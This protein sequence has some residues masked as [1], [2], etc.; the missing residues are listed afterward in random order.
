MLGGNLAAQLKYN[1]TWVFGSDY[2]FDIPGIETTIIDFNRSPP[3]HRNVVGLIELTTG[4]AQIS[5]PIS[6]RLLFYTNGCKIID[7]THQVMENG[8]RI[9]E[10]EYYN[11]FCEGSIGYYPLS[12]S[13]L[14]LPNLIEDHGYYMIHK[15]KYFDSLVCSDLRYSYIDMSKNNG[16][17]SVTIKN[18]LIDDSKNFS[19]GYLTA[20]KHGNQKDWWIIQSR[21]D[22]NLFH[23]YLLQ[24]EGIES[25][26][27]Q[28]IG[29]PLWHPGQATFTPDGMRYVAYDDGKG[30]LCMDFN[31][32]TGYFSNTR[33]AQI[34]YDSLLGGLAISPNS[35]FAYAILD[36]EIYQVD[37]ME[38]DLSD[39]IV[40]V[41]TAREDIGT[42]FEQNFGSA[43]LGPDCKVYVAPGS[44]SRAMHVIHKPD[45]KGIECDVRQ[46]DVKFF[47][48]RSNA[49]LHS[50]INYNIDEER[51]CDPTITM[52]DATQL[53]D[54]L[55]IKI[56]PNPTSDYIIVQNASIFS[57]ANI[58]IYDLSGRLVH[59]THQA[60]DQKID[61]RSLPKGIYIIE[62]VTDDF[63]RWRTK[64][65]KE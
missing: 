58:N 64:F 35:R 61:V 56:A 38:E 22:S 39:G 48:S 63:K 7:S 3:E 51:Y 1:Y 43:T 29:V 36:K 27:V 62:C 17:G 52:Y 57:E 20:I 15:T 60:L 59:H 4:P 16:L 26:D 5:D 11:N 55:D 18:Q 23:T 19:C 45:L 28:E 21:Q 53:P 50:Y 25:F 34:K 30:I 24:N 2:D 40:K 33:F 37:L 12:N 41:A 32:N 54:H 9:N 6:G 49:Y 31:R 13:I 47:Y 14:L 44:G 65:V 10:G 42:W 8:D 46:Q